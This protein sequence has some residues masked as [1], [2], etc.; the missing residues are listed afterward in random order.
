MSPGYKLYYVSF[1][2]VT[3]GISDLTLLNL[4]TSDL[5]L[6][7]R[8]VDM[9][10]SS[11]LSVQIYYVSRGC[12]K[13]KGIPYTVVS[14]EDSL[15][16]CPHYFSNWSLQGMPGFSFHSELLPSQHCTPS[17]ALPEFPAN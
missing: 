12:N 1:V 7:P 15:L 13:H 17:Y 16:S 11:I 9:L 8:E 4:V 3:L 10:D 6:H 2:I 14:L 5:A